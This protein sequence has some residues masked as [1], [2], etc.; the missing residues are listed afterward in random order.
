M[1]EVRK[2]TVARET[3]EETRVKGAFAEIPALS[4]RSSGWPAVKYAVG[5]HVFSWSAIHQTGIFELRCA[6]HGALFFIREY[7]S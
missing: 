5:C 2:L 6:L 3:S 7:T 1:I 4:S